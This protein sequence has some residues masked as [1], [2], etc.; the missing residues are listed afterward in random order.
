MTITIK[1]SHLLLMKKG[2]WQSFSIYQSHSHYLQR[3]SFLVLVIRFCK[4]S[5]NVTQEL[6]NADRC[7]AQ[8]LT[9]QL[10]CLHP[11]LWCLSWSFALVPGSA[12]SHSPSWSP[13]KRTQLDC[14]L[15]TLSWPRLVFSIWRMT[16]WWKSPLLFFCLSTK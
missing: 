7:L 16:I 11:R 10:R 1:K 6:Q 14:G 12:S 4:Y 15:L 2:L 9:C 8:S 3:F 13:M 5:R